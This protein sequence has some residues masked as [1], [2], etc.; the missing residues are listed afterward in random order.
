MNPLNLDGMSQFLGPGLGGLWMGEQQG[1]A[2][3]AEKLRQQKTLDEMMTAAQNRDIAKQKLPFELDEMRARAGFNE[4]SA[5]E[6]RQRTAAGQVKL[7]KEKFGN[8][9]DTLSVTGFDPNNPLESATRVDQI[10]K[11]QGLDPED[12]RIAMV[13]RATSDPAAWKKLTDAWALNQPDQRRK[14]QEKDAEIEGRLEQE[15]LQQRGA[16]GRQAM[17]NQNAKDVEQM[18]I[19]AG[20]YEKTNKIVVGLDNELARAKGAADKLAV[21]NQYIG[22]ASADPDLAN[23]V[24]KLLELRK[25]FEPQARAELNQR[26]NPNAINVPAV[27]GLPAVPQQP[28]S[29]NSAQGPA[30]SVPAPRQM[31][32]QDQQAMAWARANPQ[33]PRAKAILQKLGVQ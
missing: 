17:A 12:P 22:L 24:P 29:A 18:R 3:D 33:D 25:Q 7:D 1:L 21:V 23:L 14:M 19:D 13:R 15:R 10:I 2:V 20:K 30:S 16:T 4:A 6:S 31:T 5:G 11:Q 27:T 26:A 28:L 8:L 9:M 32:P